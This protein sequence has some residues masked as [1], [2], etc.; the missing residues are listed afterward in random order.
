MARGKQ[1]TSKGEYTVKNRDKYVGV[2]NPRY[3]SSWELVVFK[4]LDHHPDVI[5][6]GAEN[7]II[8]YYSTADGRKRRYMVDIYMKYRDKQGKIRK[9]LVEIKPF[10]ETQPPKN[11]KRKKTS[12]YLQ[13]V[14]TFAVN[15]DK[16]KAATKYA[17][18]RKMEFRI[19][20]EHGIF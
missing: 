12:T 20:T 18:D 11:S 15:T 19:L 10:K 5:E 7:V 4:K 13:E 9:E 2:G 14:Y 1:N 3:L 6:W 16:W 8:P 17:K